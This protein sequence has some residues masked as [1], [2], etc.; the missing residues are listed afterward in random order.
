LSPHNNTPWTQYWRE[1]TA[2]Q[3]AL[4]IA[5]SDGF[6]VT[7]EEGLTRIGALMG[8]TAKTASSVSR[9]A[10]ALTTRGL[11]E[12]SNLSSKSI[13]ALTDPVFELWIRQNG[14][15]LLKGT[16]PLIGSRLPPNGHREPR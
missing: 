5:A 12:R 6:Q 3:Q 13:Y 9:A 1:S 14:T 2:L 8:T 16:M 10:S 11:I 4:L 7:T 15:A